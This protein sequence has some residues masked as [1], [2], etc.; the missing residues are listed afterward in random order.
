[1]EKQILTPPFFLFEGLSLDIFSDMT[2]LEATIEPNDWQDNIYKAFDW[3]GKQLIFQVVAE[4]KRVW[5][6]DCKIDHTRFKRV[7]ASRTDEFL[8]CLQQSYQAYFSEDCIELDCHE[9][10]QRLIKKLGIV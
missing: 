2:T 8:Y 4:T 7:Q 9:L 3:D 1:M 5:L 10:K 6:S